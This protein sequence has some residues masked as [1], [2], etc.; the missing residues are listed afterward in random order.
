LTCRSSAATRTRANSNRHE[1]PPIILAIGDRNRTGGAVIQALLGTSETTPLPQMC[2]RLGEAL[3]LENP[4]PMAVLRRAI[5]D[6]GFAADLI[7]CRNTPAFLAALFDDR[8]TRAYAPAAE[9]KPAST[10]ALAAKAAAA[11]T[12]WG[13]AGFSIVDEAT[14]ARRE[15]ACLAC[16]NLGEP[17]SLLQKLVP[18]GAADG[19][20]GQHL[21]GKICTLCGCIA[22][23]KIRLPTEA[24]PDAHPTR[25]G[26]TRWG[27]AA[28]SPARSNAKGLPHA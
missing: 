12:R 22:G 7:T 13:R 15:R 9:A 1:P 23:K 4:V 17:R 26:V 28:P 21:G 6:P 18:A 24:C 20:T 10:L 5:D 3:G 19:R 16:P 27:E 14:L 25:A 11:L 8:R 2:A